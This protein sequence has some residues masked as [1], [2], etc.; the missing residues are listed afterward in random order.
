ME[1]LRDGECKQV[2]AGNVDRDDTVFAVMTGFG[3]LVIS[4]SG[5]RLTVAPADF[6][7]IPFTNGPD[8]GFSG[9]AD[10]HT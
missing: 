7:L 4:S 5:F 9:Q 6:K 1:Y 3:D 8:F 2:N 10:E